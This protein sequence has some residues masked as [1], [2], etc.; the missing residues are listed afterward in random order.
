[1]SQIFHPLSPVKTQS[2]LKKIEKIDPSH[3]LRHDHVRMMTRKL[4]FAPSWQELMCEDYSSVPFQMKRYLYNDVMVYPVAY[5]NTPYDHNHFKD[6]DLLITDEN[7]AD[8]IIF[9]YGLYVSGS[10]RLT[11]ISCVDDIEW[12]EDLPPMTR[13][14]LEKD[15]THYPKIKNAPEGF[16]ITMPCIFR[17]S[18]MIITFFVTNDG[19]VEIQDRSSLVDD[20]PIKNFA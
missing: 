18:I 2:L 3:G 10:D 14:S 12:Q 1:M 8:Y 15:F 4:S 5:S 11:P 19:F 7:I 13:Q 16:I 9:Y 6:L 17:Q 20:L